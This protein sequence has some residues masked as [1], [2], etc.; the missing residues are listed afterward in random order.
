MQEYVELTEL[1]TDIEGHPLSLLFI[2][3][4][5]CGVCDVTYARTVELLKQYPQVKSMV[6][7]ME[8][9]PNL[10]GEFLVFTAPAILLFMDGKE[11]FRQARFVS[12]DE[13]EHVLKLTVDAT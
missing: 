2:K 7:S 4:A 13:L 1:L 8:K 6:A 10:S 12:F 9:M 5:N 3:T 11:V